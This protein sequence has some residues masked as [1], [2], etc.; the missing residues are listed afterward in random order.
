MS[1]SEKRD[2]RRRLERGSM[3]PR[4]PPGFPGV[5]AGGYLNF[6]TSRV[7]HSQ[8]SSAFSSRDQNTTRVDRIFDGSDHVGD[9][10]RKLRRRPSIEAR[11]R[12]SEYH[13]L[14][15]GGNLCSDDEVTDDLDTDLREPKQSEPVKKES[16]NTQRVQ[17]AAPIPDAAVDAPRQSMISVLYGRQDTDSWYLTRRLARL[18]ASNVAASL[19]PS[20]LLR[21][22]NI[23]A[24]A[25]ELYQLWR[26]T[27]V[28]PTRYRDVNFDPEGID[29]QRTWIACWP[30][31][32]AA[33]HGYV[34]ED[35]EFVDRLMGLLE[36]KVVKGIRPDS[37]TISHIFGE[38]RHHMPTALGRFLVDRWV[39][40][41]AEGFCDVDLFDLPQHF[42]YVAL[43]SAMK[44]L[45]CDERPSSL[46]DCQ[47]HTHAQSEDCYKRRMVP[48]AKRQERYRHRREK[49]SREAEQVAADSIEYGITTVDWEGRRVEEHR[50]L[51]EESDASLPAFDDRI[52][53]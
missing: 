44:R 29:P 15:E 28:I 17:L 3:P 30:L 43:E 32:N 36:E 6:G 51:R 46:P 45:S 41:A 1:F 39:D 16:S 24:D 13:N 26:R 21:R 33:I 42:V 20:T 2:I 19:D 5:G 49:A 48:E 7:P 23:D 12:K 10:G 4:I 22:R 27:G 11:A 40:C 35:I 9:T 38:N 52:G 47:Y 53:T 37:D 25:A 14:L 18:P 31:I 34:V 50:K 8:N